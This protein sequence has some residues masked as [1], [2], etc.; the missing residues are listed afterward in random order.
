MVCKSTRSNKKGSAKLVH[1]FCEVA[2]IGDRAPRQGPAPSAGADLARSMPQFRCFGPEP[3][4]LPP[5]AS[6]SLGPRA[7][8]PPRDAGPTS[9]R[10]TRSCVQRGDGRCAGCPGAPAMRIGRREQ[11]G[12][13]GGLR[14]PRRGPRPGLGEQSPAL[15]AAR[16]NCGP[17]EPLTGRRS[18]TQAR[19]VAA[20]WRP[21][22]F[23]QLS[24]APTPVSSPWPPRRRALLAAPGKRDRRGSPEAGWAAPVARPRT[25][26]AAPPGPPGATLAP[27]AGDSLAKPRRRVSQPRLLELAW[28]LRHTAR[29]AA[30]KPI[31]E[32]RPQP[33]AAGLRRIPGARASVSARRRAVR[34]RP[35]G[36]PAE[37][38]RQPATDFTDPLGSR[39][40]TTRLSSARPARTGAGC[41]DT[42]WCRQPRPA[43]AYLPRR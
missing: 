6:A 10:H 20:A 43:P 36:R 13:R 21:A 30:P 9:L 2:C 12:A 27:D 40:R 22:A 35:D 5:Q 39:P 34:K 42:V 15:R 18:P 4:S 17:N 31:R 11:P 23:A 25:L 24:A 41:D 26:A 14:Q 32:C 8:Q 19:P 38:G 29:P 33:S 1:T 7:S 28:A 16:R 37:R 3:S